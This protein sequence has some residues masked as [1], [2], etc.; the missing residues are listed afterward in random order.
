[1]CSPAEQKGPVGGDA[2]DRPEWRVQEPVPDKAPC[3]VP[4]RFRADAERRA[5]QPMRQRMEAQC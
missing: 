5:D 3:A 1:M 2:G 4:P